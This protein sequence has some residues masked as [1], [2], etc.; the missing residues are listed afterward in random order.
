MDINEAWKKI[1]EEKFSSSTIKKEEI[2]NAI[3]K[4]SSSTISELKKRLKYKMYWATFFV[5]AFVV[6]AL[7]NLD[8]PYLL[9]I[10]GI[11]IILYSFGVSG[12]Y[13]EYKDMEDHIDSSKDTLSEMKKQ[14]DIMKRAL[15]NE[16]RWGYISFPIIIFVA[17]I[18]PKIISGIPI[19]ELFTDLKFMAILIIS[20]LVL[21]TGGMWLG[22]K[23]NEKGYGSFLKKLEDNIKKME[24]L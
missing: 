17:L 24:E 19:V 5:I 10:F 8:N 7:L 6:G 4:E 18:S 3:S 9:T 21:T 13:H 20:I 1:N 22:K 14:R 12:L 11:G 23:M 2:M 15:K 16:Q